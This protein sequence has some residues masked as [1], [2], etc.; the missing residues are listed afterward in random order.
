MNMLAGGGAGAAAAI[1]EQIERA[2]LNDRVTALAAAL[3]ELNARG[4]LDNENFFLPARSERYVRK[5]L[6]RD[7]ADR[8]VM[9]GITWPPGLATPLHDHGGLWGAESVVTGTMRE[10]TYRAIECDTAHGTRFAREGDV[11]LPERSVGIL[12]PPLEYHVYHN[13]TDAVAHT[14][15]V[16]S[17]PLEE[18]NTY[19]PSGGDW[20]TAQRRTLQY[21][22]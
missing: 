8:F 5:L 2:V 11:M 21:D 17:G 20:W 19:S 16:Y 1:V 4:L 10:S 15:H 7:P 14:V 22:A 12:V 6:W 9:I 3:A 18:C 13:V